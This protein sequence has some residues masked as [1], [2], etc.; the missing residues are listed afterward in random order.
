M[1]GWKIWYLMYRI[2]TRIEPDST[3]LATTR[4]SSAVFRF[5]LLHTVVAWLTIW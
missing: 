5:W 2:A 3:H 1:R 4:G